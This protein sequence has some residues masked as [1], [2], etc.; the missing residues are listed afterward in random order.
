MGFFRHQ[1]GLAQAPVIIFAK[2]SN[3]TVIVMDQAIVRF[4]PASEDR[5][6]KGILRISAQ[7]IGFQPQTI[8]ARVE[9][10]ANRE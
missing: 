1:V 9:H 4:W 6:L 7:K 10:R 2:E 8:A 5:L 3:A